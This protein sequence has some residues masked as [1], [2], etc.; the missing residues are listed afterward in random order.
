[1]KKILLLLSMCLLSLSGM[2]QSETEN[3]KDTTQVIDM[4]RTFSVGGRAI[5]CM[6]S[7]HVNKREAK[8]LQWTLE[9]DRVADQ[10]FV[11]LNVVN[12]KTGDVEVNQHWNGNVQVRMLNSEKG[13]I[14]EVYDDTFSH[15][16]I[17]QYKS[18]VYIIM[19]YSELRKK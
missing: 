3:A 11:K 4:G 14:Y 17:V 12:V 16:R 6:R 1:M 15:L 13:I 8:A 10:N 18:D 19:F 7:S 2:A 5:F 9:N